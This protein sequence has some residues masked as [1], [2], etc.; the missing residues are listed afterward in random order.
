MTSTSTAIRAGRRVPPP[1]AAGVLA[2]A[3]EE[4]VTARYDGGVALVRGLVVYHNLC[5]PARFSSFQFSGKPGDHR[6]LG[7]GYRKILIIK[8]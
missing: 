5:S 4:A 8:G 1:V 6:L 7:S 2:G 3:V